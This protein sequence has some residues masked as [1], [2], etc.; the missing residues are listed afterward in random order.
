MMLKLL[1]RDA[2]SSIFSWRLI[3]KEIISIGIAWGAWF[4]FQDPAIQSTVPGS[5]ITFLPFLFWATV[6]ISVISFIS[7]S[8]KSVLPAAIAWALVVPLFL[9]GFTFAGQV[10]LFIANAAVVF[11]AIGFVYHGGRLSQYAATRS[12]NA[13]P[14]AVNTWK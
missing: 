6:V 4:T 7:A 11:Y 5:V 14:L 12:K 9:M 8:A 13:R 2:A 1:L 3:I 10:S